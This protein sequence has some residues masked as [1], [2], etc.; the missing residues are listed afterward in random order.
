LA[1]WCSSEL[2]KHASLTWAYRGQESAVIT[3]LC[4]L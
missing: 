2:S 3:N 4:H 1:A